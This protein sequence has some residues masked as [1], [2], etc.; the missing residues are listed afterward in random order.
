M[1]QA[2]PVTDREQV[3]DTLIT[4]TRLSN[5]HR[6]IVAGDDSTELCLALRRRG[7]VRVATPS[8]PR[9]ARGQHTIAL[10]TARRSPAATEAALMQVSQFLAANATIAVL[11]DFCDASVS[12]RIRRKLEQMGFRIEAGVRCHEGLVLS[13]YRQGFAQMERVA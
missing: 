6:A 4:L 13:A 5:L 11:I 9:L 2:H 10:V 12:F 3:I 8:T 7:F 1:M